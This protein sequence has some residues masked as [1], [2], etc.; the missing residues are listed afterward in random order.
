MKIKK[1]LAVSL[2]LV[3]S[4][5]CKK[6]SNS[7][8]LVVSKL[9]GKNWRSIEYSI[10]GTSQ[11]QWCGS[12]LKHR[13]YEGGKYERTIGRVVRGCLSEYNEGDIIESTYKISTD[14]K[15]LIFNTEAPTSRDS[16]EIISLTEDRLETK[17]TILEG[18]ILYTFE[19]TF[20][21]Q[22]E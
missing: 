6:E 15:W 2:L 12:T 1:L 13:Y 8:N 11:I 10:D 18:D 20:V 19:E 16:F 22:M 17:Q 4:I 3:F 5:S 14:N 21:V 7:T 9:I